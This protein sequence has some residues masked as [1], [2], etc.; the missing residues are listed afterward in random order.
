MSMC[1]VVPHFRSTDLIQPVK[2]QP[3]TVHFK[4]SFPLRKFKSNPDLVVVK[5]IEQNRFDRIPS[6]TV[7]GPEVM[8]IHRRM[9]KINSRD[10]KMEKTRVYVRP[11]SLE[12][13]DC[14][15]KQNRNL[16]V[17]NEI[18]EISQLCQEFSDQICLLK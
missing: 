17:E 4:G 16:A 9:E 12:T 7:C 14:R 5:A 1:P 11:G 6:P 2:Q 8:L 10:K 3:D 18:G 13:G 15:N